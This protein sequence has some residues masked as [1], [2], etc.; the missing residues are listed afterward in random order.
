MSSASLIQ[1]VVREIAE[2]TGDIV[3]V[4]LGSTRSGD[5]PAFAPGSHVELTIP[6]G[7]RRHYSIC[8]DPDDLS[9]YEIA[10][11]REPQSRGGSDYIHDTL[12]EGDVMLMTSPRSTFPIADDAQHHVLLAGGIG[13]APFVPMI[14]RFAKAEASYELHYLARTPDD[15]AL[16][17]RLA[18]LCG[19]RLSTHFS[20]AGGR[21]AL[22]E[23]L[24]R[25]DPD[26][27]QIYC[28]GPKRLM[29]QVRSLTAGTPGRTPR[30]EAFSG[31]AVAPVSVGAPFDVE[32]ASSG[33]LVAVRADETLL[34]ALRRAGCEVASSCEHG[35][36][37]TCVIGF[38]AGD[39]IHRDGVL[40]EELRRDHIAACVSRA[41]GRMTLKL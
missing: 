38:S 25:L 14:H 13:I 27:A 24:G 8:S 6:N 28:C 4:Q 11:L 32:I 22:A 40:N 9:H 3:T 39:A 23:L 12:A 26:Q 16:L 7:V 36:C 30:F 18:G 19:T 35:I 17:H 1:V 10:V 37:G 15:A 2:E 33:K 29:D 31:V 5:M 34:Q 20:R 21:L 41:K